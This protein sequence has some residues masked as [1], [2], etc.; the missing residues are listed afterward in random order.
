MWNSCWV[1]AVGTLDEQ[2]PEIIATPLLLKNTAVGITLTFNCGSLLNSYKNSEINKL[3]YP[4]HE[5][6]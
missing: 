2:G 1:W 3:Q 6:Y 4:P 5:N